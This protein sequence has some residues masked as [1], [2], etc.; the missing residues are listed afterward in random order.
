MGGRL[1]K[2]EFQVMEALWSRGQL[3]IREI[4]E[5]IPARKTPAY[6]TV[7]TTVYRMEAKG[8]VR[9][10]KK[11]GSNFHVFEAVI[12]RD[13]AQRR[14]IDDLLGYFGGRSQPLMAHL[15]ESGELSLGDV[16]EAE[17]LLK[18][19]KGGR[20]SS[21]G[22][23]VGWRSW[24]VPLL[25]H[26]CQSTVFGGGVWLLTLALRRNAARLRYRL[27]MA[28]SLKFLLPFSLFIAVGA[29][30]PWPGHLDGAKPAVATVLQG[31]AQ[32]LLQMWPAD[33]GT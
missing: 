22:I 6:T 11:S 2:F 12:T 5:E 1:S 20:R 15:I 33:A 27:W 29:R 19:R 14:V 28:A 13:T 26:L 24:V 3:S 32:P 4:Q 7:Q 31:V 9:R 16:R 23:F 17:K 21:D 8:V 10:V 25:H 30:L 18:S